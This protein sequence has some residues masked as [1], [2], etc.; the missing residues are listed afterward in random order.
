MRTA[1]AVLGVIVGCST[2]VAQTPAFKDSLKIET[3]GETTTAP[4]SVPID[5]PRSA[6]KG[7]LTIEQ[8]GVKTAAPDRP[9]KGSIRIEDAKN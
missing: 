7:A 2:A 6:F 3:P 4:N 8:D 5:S 9:L 1:A